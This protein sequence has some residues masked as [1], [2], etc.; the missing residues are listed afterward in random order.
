MLVMSKIFLPMLSILVKTIDLSF[1]P[2][3][4][5]WKSCKNNFLNKADKRW[6]TWQLVYD[7]LIFVQNIKI[8]I[9]KTVYPILS[10]GSNEVD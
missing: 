1:V 5:K 10:M 4:S 8:S 7:E 3:F 2:I 9:P 6:A